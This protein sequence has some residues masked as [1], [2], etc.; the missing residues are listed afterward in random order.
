M[1]RVARRPASSNCQH[2]SPTSSTLKCGN[3]L[4][5]TPS[6]NVPTPRCKQTNKQKKTQQTKTVFDSSTVVIQLFR[7]FDWIEWLERIAKPSVT[8]LDAGMRR[9]FFPTFWLSFVSGRS[10]WFCPIDWLPTNE[11]MTSSVSRCQNKESCQF[12]PLAIMSHVGQA[13]GTVTLPDH[14]AF[15]WR[16]ENV[17][18]I[19]MRCSL[20]DYYLDGDSCYRVSWISRFFVIDV[21]MLIRYGTV[22]YVD[23]TCLADTEESW[24]GW[25]SIVLPSTRRWL[26][27]VHRQSRLSY[28]FKG[29]GRF[30]S[31]DHRIGHPHLV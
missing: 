11:M 30:D 9:Y 16:V 21:I 28:H 14:Y 29:A 23:V 25:S 17:S 26:G 10:N 7:S 1:F 15:T 27:S 3:V 13:D 22:H 6:P 4:T 12:D 31:V 24:M 19:D 8:N 5:A 18:T 2:S 20:P